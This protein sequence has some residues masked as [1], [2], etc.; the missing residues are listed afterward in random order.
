MS[1]Q[2]IKGV[3][4]RRLI[5]QSDAFREGVNA[6]SFAFAHDLIGHPLMEIPRLARLGGD[7]VRDVGEHTVLYSLAESVPNTRKQWENFTSPQKIES[8]IANIEGSGSWVNIK[9]AQA[10]PEYQALLDL[11]IVE[12]ERAM[13]KPLRRELTWAEMSVFIGSPHSVTHYHMDSETNFLFQ[14][15]GTK[16]A[17]IFDRSVLAEEEIEQFYFGNINAPTYR[18]EMELQSKVYDFAPGTGIH[19][20]VNAPHWVRNL[21]DYSVSLSILLY[22][23][24]TDARARTYQVNHLLRRLGIRPAPHGASPFRDRCKA[25]PLHL[26]STRS[27]KSKRDVIHS[28]LDRVKS[29]ASR[30]NRLRR[31]H[32]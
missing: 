3:E 4:S 31:K 13:E 28:G 11:L 2:V 7:L 15:H 29:V 5:G 20:P 18:P 12:I 17:H 9:D 16:E 23:R 26:L 25:T 14:I 24:E 10:D 21:G 32:A 30:M 6:R 1:G 8:A 22:L 27:P 19:I